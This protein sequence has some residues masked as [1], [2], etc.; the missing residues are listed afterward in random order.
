MNFYGMSSTRRPTGPQQMLEGAGNILLTRASLESL[1]APWFHPAFALSGGEDRGFPE[2]LA[3]AGKR[4]AWAT[5][6]LAHTVV[7][8]WA[9]RSTG[10]L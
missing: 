9:A 2:R 3:Q 8:L 10:L 1:G 5:K 6:E 7:P 4:F